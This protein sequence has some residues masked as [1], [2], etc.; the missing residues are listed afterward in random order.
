MNNTVLLSSFMDSFNKV[1]IEDDRWK[2]YLE[3]MA[4][5]IAVS[6]LAII[7]GV[8]IGL[9]VA[10]V[11]N[12]NLNT[13]K[14]KIL[15]KIGDFY[16]TVIRGIP[17]MV[18]LLFMYFVV[19]FA[20]DYKIITGAIVFGINSGAYV[21]E[22][23]RGGIMSIDKGQM[24]AGRSLGLS[25]GKTMSKVIVP[26]AM[27]NAIPPLG[28]EF[29]ALIKETAIIGTIGIVDI[30]KAADDI[31]SVTYEFFLPLAAAALM[32]LVIVMTLTKVMKIV[33][34]RLGKS[35]TRS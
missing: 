21:A 2:S 18:Q 31:R 29:I 15:N 13:G 26:Q 27:K 8:A 17:V 25:Y 11:K 16:V 30:T 32:Y 19:L 3:G 10:I 23:F 14:L 22:I 5:T 20:F 1:F 24:E 33:E 6:I 34:R 9:T 28:N 4:V 35:D 12:I 7:I